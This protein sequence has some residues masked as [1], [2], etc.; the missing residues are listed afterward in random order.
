MFGIFEKA[1]FRNVRNLCIAA[2]NTISKLLRICA[3]GSVLKFLRTYAKTLRV[4]IR[5]LRIYA[6]DT[7]LSQNWIFCGY[8]SS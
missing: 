4:T 3:D 1:C 8:V 2:N 5:N 7:L 6:N